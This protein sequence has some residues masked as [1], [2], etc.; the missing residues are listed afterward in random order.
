MLAIFGVLL[1][2]S[3]ENFTR[4]IPSLQAAFDAGSRQSPDFLSKKGSVLPDKSV[5]SHLNPGSV[6]SVVAGLFSG[7][8]SVFLNIVLI[9]PPLPSCCLK[10]RDSRINCA[11]RWES[12]TH[13][14]RAIKFA[15]DLKHYLIIKTASN[16]VFGVLTWFF[17]T[18]LGVEFAVLWGLLA[19]LL[20]YIPNIGSILAAIPAVLLVL[21]E[22][23]PGR[24]ALV[25]AGM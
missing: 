3:I 25:I 17:L 20:H 2:V 22:A 23:G 4:T 10:H 11:E 18:I 21:I 16:L 19:F 12:P 8:S 24:A 7:L 14:S 15:D 13:R 5:L 1:G 6:M 9:L